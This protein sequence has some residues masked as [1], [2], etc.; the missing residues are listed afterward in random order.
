MKASFSWFWLFA[1]IL[2][3]LQSCTEG[4]NLKDLFRFGPEQLDSN[5]FHTHNIHEEFLLKIPKYMKKDSSLHPDAVLAYRNNRKEM[6]VIVIEEVK[7]PVWF[8]LKQDG[9]YSDSLSLSMNYL[10]FH[11][12]EM[13]KNQEVK[14]S[15]QDSV[16]IDN[17]NAAQGILETRINDKE[18]VYLGTTI[19]GN[20]KIFFII[21]YTS[22]KNYTK[23]E[24]TFKQIIS[25]F[26]LLETIEENEY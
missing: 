12:K 8:R 3:G 7:I 18:M 25:S 9:N 16:I 15:R 1:A 20:E 6:G 4:G 10:Q 13:I 17:R 26:Q 21:C 11:W 24:M 19:E 14:L 22:Q 5:D 23:F 2:M